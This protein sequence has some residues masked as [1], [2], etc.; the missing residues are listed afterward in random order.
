MGILFWLFSFNL[1]N[2]FIFKFLFFYFLNIIDLIYTL[3]SSALANDMI[4]ISSTIS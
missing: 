1:I 3:T 2:K 4:L